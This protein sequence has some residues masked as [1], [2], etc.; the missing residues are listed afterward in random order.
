[1]PGFPVLHHLPELAQTHVH[2]VGDVSNHLILCRLLLLLP[3]IFPRIRVF[4]N[5]LVLCI[6]WPKYWRFSIRPSNEYSGLISFRIDCFDLL[7]VQGTLKSLLQ[8][9]SILKE[10]LTPAATGVN[11]E[12]V[13]LSEISKS[14]KDTVPSHYLESSNS[15]K[16]KV[17]WCLPRAAPMERCCLISVEF[18]FCKWRS[19]GDLLHNSGNLLSDT[20]LPRWFS[21]KE[22]VCQCRRC[23]F[24]AWVGKI[25][26]RSQW[27]SIQ[28]S[29][30]RNPMDRGA[31]WATVHGVT[32]KID[33]T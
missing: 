9:Y 25:P 24:D 19:S 27:Q 14:L 20:G 17:E 15:Y 1:M 22:S 13:M 32:E 29:C 10:I 3:S 2:W 7:A 33:M 5:E 28:Y 31:W 21:G 11:L 16:Q 23:R 8:H 4:S 6:R 26:R 18:Q 30:L 12:D